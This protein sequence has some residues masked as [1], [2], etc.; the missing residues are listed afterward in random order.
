LMRMEMP[1]RM[2]DLRLPNGSVAS[3]VTITASAIAYER[4]IATGALLP[5][6]PVP[7]A[8]LWSTPSL[9]LT[10]HAKISAT[11]TA[12][13]QSSECLYLIMSTSTVNGV[14]AIDLLSPVDIEDTDGDGMPEIVDAWGNP[15]SWVRWPAGSEAL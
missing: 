4:D 14:S 3:P 1:D 12:E 6:Q 8:V 15:I 2:T 11:W 9:F 5:L 7:R 10:Y 13:H